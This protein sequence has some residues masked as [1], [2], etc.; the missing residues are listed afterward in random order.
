MFRIPGYAGPADQ[1]PCDALASGQASQSCAT[2]ARNLVPPPW[3]DVHPRE[4]KEV[5]VPSGSVSF[6]NAASPSCATNDHFEYGYIFTKRSLQLQQ[7]PISNLFRL[8]ELDR[9]RT[10]ANT[11]TGKPE[12]RAIEPVVPA[13]AI[14]SPRQGDPSVEQL[15]EV[16]TATMTTLVGRSQWTGGTGPTE[17]MGPAYFQE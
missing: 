1:D 6:L 9:R 14:T 17:S 5:S 4:T 15:K 11:T 8:F 3:T 10:F 13:T 2:G 7:A 16:K 12:Q